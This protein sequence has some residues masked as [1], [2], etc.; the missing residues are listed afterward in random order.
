MVVLEHEGLLQRVRFV[1]GDAGVGGCA[2]DYDVVLDQDTILEDGDS[3]WR[4]NP[5]T[6]AKP[7]SVEDNVIRLPF[8]G[9]AASVDQWSMLFVNGS[10]LPMEIGF[11]IVGIQH[12][13]FVIPLEEDAAVATPLHG[14]FH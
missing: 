6:D 12:L 1:F 11:V 13:D 14:A 4:F 10:S 7:G 3:A 2:F 5:A 9:F 8:A